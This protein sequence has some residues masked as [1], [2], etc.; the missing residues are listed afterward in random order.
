MNAGVMNETST[1]SIQ[2][3]VFKVNSDLCVEGSNITSDHLLAAHATGALNERLGGALQCMHSFDSEKGCGFGTTCPNCT[4]RHAILECFLSGTVVRKRVEMNLRRNNLSTW[5]KF[6]ITANRVTE[7]DKKFV[8]L[9]VEDL[10]AALSNGK[11]PVH[12]DGT[13]SGNE[14]L[15][16]D[17]IK[18]HLIKYRTVTFQ[19]LV[20]H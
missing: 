12:I 14:C 18:D 3:A 17:I 1:Q 6:I 15:Y 20:Q 16:Y 8:A 11:L 19:P 4:V 2:M 5:H 9:I 10:H 13:F 7:A